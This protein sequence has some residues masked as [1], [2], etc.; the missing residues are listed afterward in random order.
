[1]ANNYKI[2]TSDFFVNPYNFV[3]VDLN[4]TDRLNI[5]DQNETVYTGYM[6]CHLK[7]RTPLAIPDVDKGYPIQVTGSDGKV[8]IH[9]EYPFVGMK[10]PGNEPRIPGSSIRGPVRNVYE[11]LT[12]SCFG[13]MKKDTLISA[14]GTLY[15]P[16]LL[17]RE[18]G[19]W[20]LYKAKQYLIVIDEKLYTSQSLDK[21]RIK[22]WKSKEL[23]GKTGVKVRFKVSRETDGYTSSRTGRFIGKYVE[24]F[25]T[26]D[27]GYNKEGYLSIGENLSNRHFQR[28][29]EKQG[30]LDNHENITKH[31][32]EKLEY[33]LQSYRNK[34]INT[35]YEEN[36]ENLEDP[37]VHRGY[38]DY[39]AAKE[40]GVIPVYYTLV[41]SNLYM[42]FAALGR[43]IYH[44]T[45]NDMVK[46]KS[47]QKCDDRTKL[48]PACAIFGT[49]EGQG[50]AS[51]IRFTDAVCTN[52]TP[53]KLIEKV[54]FE[55]LSSPRMSYIPFYLKE[56]FV[57]ANYTKGYDSSD[58]EIRGRKF[59]W[60]HKPSIDKMVPRND[61]NATFDV[62]DENTEF[63]FKIYFDGITEKQLSL[64]ASAVDLYEDDINGN[65]CHKLGHGKPLGYGSVKMIVEKCVIR[66]FD[67]QSGWEIIPKEIRR[68]DSDYSCSEKTKKELLT[69]CNFEH[70]N[71]FDVSVEYPGITADA[72]TKNMLKENKDENSLARH[73]WFTENYKVGKA[74]PACTLPQITENQELAKYEFKMQ[75]QEKYQKKKIYKAKV[76]S[77]GKNGSDERFL[78][79]DIQI[80][81][82]N[83][84]ARVFTVL[85][86]F[87]NKTLSVDQ[88]IEV[89]LL[90]RESEKIIKFKLKKKTI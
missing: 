59:Y 18:D 35:K 61:R 50:L 62:L 10:H 51:R 43:K 49:I 20:K 26:G 81:D 60:H 75:L 24:N 64:L 2:S 69:I 37:D 85:S 11:T 23:R 12:N 71:N 33:I 44:N 66:S 42:S 48:C 34:K 41:D 80:L 30:I 67:V 40:R 28:I 14:R 3:S 89:E 54:I 58:L 7:C 87:K 22:C 29:F 36:P 84:F 21:T 38:S 16:G 5:S 82:D 31:D 6:Q 65:M 32:F 86:C 1:M 9:Y 19:Q 83:S 74:K 4:N 46:E 39:E 13:T 55:E 57:D 68:K 73:R 88:E 70:C 45:L 76:L 79:Y 15:K 8:K 77:E 17:M 52:Y 78:E 90:Y 47:H 53:D 27:K 63:S 72:A 25:T 56:C